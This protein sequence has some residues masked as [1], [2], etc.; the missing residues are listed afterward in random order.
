MRPETARPRAEIRGTVLRQIFDEC[1]LT[2]AVRLGL[3]GGYGLSDADIDGEDGAIPLAA[4]LEIFESLADHQRQPT[5]GLKLSRRMGPDL[6]GAPGYL[7][8]GAP[9]LGTA[10]DE[11]VRTVFAIQGATFLDFIRAPTPMMSYF[12]V[13]QTLTS[14]RQDAEFSLAY[15][16]QLICLFLGTPYAPVELTFEHARLAPLSSYERHFGCP[17]YFEQARNSLIMRPQDLTLKARRHDPRL[18]SLL[19]HYLTMIRPTKDRP[20]RV[21]DQV[22]AVLAKTVGADPVTVADVAFR[23]G[24]TEHTLR[25]K[26]SAEGVSFRELLRAKKIAVAMRQLEDTEFSILD[27]AQKLGYSDA[28]AFTRA[29]RAET[30]VSPSLHRK[31][32]NR[33]RR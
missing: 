19:R 31:Q 28:A 1:A 3:L 29:F 7:F 27:I 32:V 16:H 26:L 24:T 8:L 2:D 5:L 13:D 20:S 6:A 23:L 25:R 21:T 22:D 10:I 4:Y 14:R 33:L 12:I 18:A 17:V 15:M 11:F 30:G 9:D